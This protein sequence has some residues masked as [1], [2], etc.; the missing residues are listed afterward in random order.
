MRSGRERTRDVT[1]RGA[2]S[3]TI[4]RTIYERKNYDLLLFMQ[5]HALH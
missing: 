5:R 1:C 2:R 4:Q 3:K